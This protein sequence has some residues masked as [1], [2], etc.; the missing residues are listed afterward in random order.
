MMGVSKV[1]DTSSSAMNRTAFPVESTSW[2]VASGIPVVEAAASRQA[3]VGDRGYKTLAWEAGT[4]QQECVGWRDQSTAVTAVES[5]SLCVETACLVDLWGAVAGVSRRSPLQPAV[6]AVD[7]A[8]TRLRL[9][10]VRLTPKGLRSGLLLGDLP[11]SS[12]RS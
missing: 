10:S 5:R 8:T 4:E 3:E 1:A 9:A 12:G 6:A 2:S 7:P 11:Q